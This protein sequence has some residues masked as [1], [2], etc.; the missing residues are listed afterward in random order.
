MLDLAARLAVRGLGYVEPNPAVGCVIVKHGEVIG[1]GHHRRYGSSHAEVEALKQV[2]RSGKS[3]EG[4]TVYVTL[5]PCNA[6]GKQPPC[7]DA[8]IAARVS[9]VVYAR[10]DP[11]PA[12]GGGADR[13]YASGVRVEFSEASRNATR[14]SDAFV[15][16]IT[17]GLPW[18]IVKW[19]QSID[20]RAATRTGAS[21]WI[22][23]ERSRSRVHRLRA[24]VDAIVT[25]IGTV[26]AD[27]PALTARGGWYRRRVARR[28]VIDP[29]LELPEHST[30]LRT[31]DE[32][33]LTIVCS[34]DGLRQKERWAN[35]L[36]ARGVEV[37]ALGEG[38]EVDVA[39]VMEHLASVHQASNV[40]VEAG[41][42][43]VGRMLDAGL[44]D[45]LH[46]YVAPMMMADEQ[47]KAVARG[48][49]TQML[50]DAVGFELERVKRIG[51]DVLLE[52]RRGMRG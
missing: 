11:N 25:A 12:K 8:L 31:L 3:A 44:A 52:Y 39:G 41:P 33:P 17:A 38:G 27:D 32:A 1:M 5:E 46:V 43:L 40:L 42:G 22:S 20:G 48:R 19:A 29:E 18:V 23:S 37:V 28:V 15:K 24:R 16:R 2:V 30:L 47:A 7:V 4:A 26:L 50:S 45:E 6:P 36:T 13:L 49:E 35:M 34:D 51:D 21:K 14:L 10:P 9:R